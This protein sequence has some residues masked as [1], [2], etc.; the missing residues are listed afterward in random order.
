MNIRNAGFLVILAEIIHFQM[1]RRFIFISP[2]IGETQFTRVTEIV[3]ITGFR[4]AI[5]TRHKAPVR[6]DQRLSGRLNIPCVPPESAVFEFT[7]CLIKTDPTFIPGVIFVVGAVAVGKGDFVGMA[8]LAALGHFNRRKGCD[9]NTK[10]VPGIAGRKIEVQ[11]SGRMRKVG[12]IV[13]VVVTR[14]IHV[15]AVTFTLPVVHTAGQCGIINKTG[16]F[17]LL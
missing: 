8:A 13:F 12:C 2:H 1:P 10:H 7:G 11:V 5:R 14:R 17:G 9:I 6:C 3:F 15:L 4:T 16:C